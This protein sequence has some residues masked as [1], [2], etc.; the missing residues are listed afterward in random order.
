MDNFRKIFRV[1]NLSFLFFFLC[2][3]AARILFFRQPSVFDY[4]QAVSALLA[5]HISEFKEF[6]IFT[7]FSHYG[8]TFFVYVGA[9]IFKIFGVS[10]LA[11]NTAGIIASCTWIIL[12]F[13]LAKKTL[14]KA[15]CV[16][17]FIFI[18][19]PPWNILY[20]SLFIGA[21]AE[22]FIVGTWFL[23]LLIRYHESIN[24]DRNLTAALGFVAGFGLWLTPHMAPF[25]LTALTITLM[26]RGRKKQL[27]SELSFFLIGFCI[28]YLPNI[29][30][31]IQHPGAQIYRFAGRI[32]DLNRDVLSSSNIYTVIFKKIL[33]R[34]STI[35]RSLFQVPSMVISLFGLLPTALFTAGI[36]LA[37]KKKIDTFSIFFIFT[38]WFIVFYSI[39]VGEKAPRY[40]IP[41]AVIAP[42]FIGMSG[43]VI[44]EKSK[45]FFGIFIALITLSGI[46]SIGKGVAEKKTPAY[47]EFAAWLTQKGIQRAYADPWTAYCVQFE[48]NE[49]VLLSPTLTHPVFYDR[50]PQQTGLVRN[51][52]QT[53]FIV[54]EKSYPEMAATLENNLSKLRVSY[55]KEIF[56]G[57]AVYA[58]LSRKLYPEELTG[59]GSPI[60]PQR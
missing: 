52:P 38:A 7:P 48:S 17:A 28:G 3:V 43:Q 33:W 45:I 39:L 8:G 35:P 11:W 5:K 37:W 23:L 4:D 26:R 9:L 32:L 53:V 50:W 51:A 49:R 30:Y 41:L 14:S 56:R 15:G 6:P 47:H 60:A 58:G 21:Y 2:A 19:L 34:I 13:A 36:I 20:F 54:D 18:C 22:T 27:A 12:G 57:F 29:V 31:G 55:R 59:F 10:S 42:L 16:A 1:E 44:R 24:F 46:F 40:M 25:I